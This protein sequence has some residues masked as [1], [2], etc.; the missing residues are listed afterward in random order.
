MISLASFTHLLSDFVCGFYSPSEWFCWL[1]LFSQWMILLL[2]FTHPVNDFVVEIYSPGEWVCWWVLF[3]QWVILLL[4]FTHPV[5]VF[6]VEFSPSSQ[7]FCW[8]VFPFQWVILLVSFPSPVSD[9]LV[10]FPPLT[11]WVMLLLS[12]PPLSQWVI[13]VEFFP[14]TWR[15]VGV[16]PSL[17][18]VLISACGLEI[19]L[20]TT[21]SSAV[22]G[23]ST[24]HSGQRITS[25]DHCTR[26]PPPLRTDGSARALCRLTVFH[27]ATVRLPTYGDLMESKAHFLIGKPVSRFGL[28]VR[29]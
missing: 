28:A 15:R 17:M 2:S 29:R 5:S 11:Q 8:W 24:G 13:V 18:W 20:T 21:S 27:T 14:C 7:W 10:S 25:I 1:V 3:S 19:S 6:V 26:W 4:S 16:N 12:F 9:L 22:Y 23:T